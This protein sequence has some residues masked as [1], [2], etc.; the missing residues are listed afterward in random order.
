MSALNSK[1]IIEEY[2]DKSDWRVNENSNSPYS[3]GGLNKHIIAEVSK[4]YWLRYVYPGHI[5]CAYIDG[6]V[7][8]HDLGGLTL[9][10]CGFSLSK[11]LELGVCGVPNVPHSRPAKHFGAIL[12]QIA[13]LTTIYQNEIMG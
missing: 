6:D 5:A 13:N 9:Y 2:L 10:C 12:N 4:D 1:K 8:I 3:F 7:H 11:I